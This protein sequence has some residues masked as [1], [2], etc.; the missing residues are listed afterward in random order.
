MNNNNHGNRTRVL[1]SSSPTLLRTCRG[2]AGGESVSAHVSTLQGIITRIH[3]T[4]QHDKS[5]IYKAFSKACKT[6]TYRCENVQR[7]QT[8]FCIHLRI[9]WHFMCIWKQDMYKMSISVCVVIAYYLALSQT[10]D[11]TNTINANNSKNC[12]CVVSSHLHNR[13]LKTLVDYYWKTKFTQVG[14][15][16]LQSKFHFM[17]GSRSNSLIIHVKTNSVSA[18]SFTHE[19]NCL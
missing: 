15:S 14:F 19:L 12:R 5:K 9:N 10:N 13:Y 7:W 4:F 11:Q 3:Y 1:T 17:R 6:Q 18:S 16:H 8:L 2:E